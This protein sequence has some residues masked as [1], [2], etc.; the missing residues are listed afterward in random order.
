MAMRNLTPWGSQ[1]S[2]RWLRAEPRI[3]RVG[4]R[5]SV[6]APAVAVA[7]SVLGVSELGKMSRACPHLGSVFNLAAAA[8]HNPDPTVLGG[9]P[10]PSLGLQG[11][12]T[13]CKALARRWMQRK[14]ML[15]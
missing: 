3:Q 10:S 5:C 15:L 8:Q 1:N 2:R 6:I 14:P 7:A 9:R 13:S 11:T 12:A 4:A